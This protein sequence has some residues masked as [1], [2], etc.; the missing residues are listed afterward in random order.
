MPRDEQLN[1]LRVTNQQRDN[2]VATLREAVADGR[3]G[4]DEF[5]ERVNTAM[6]ARTRGDIVDV[7]E[8]LVEPDRLDAVITDETV[9]G[10]GPGFSWDNPLVLGEEKQTRT[11]LGQWRVPPFL[12]VHASAMATVRLDFTR[13][14]TVSPVIDLVVV[15]GSNVA[16]VLIVVPEG[17]GVSTQDLRVSGQSYSTSKVRTRPT[18]GHPRILVSGTTSGTVTVRHPSWWDEYKQR[19][20][21]EQNPPSS[22][23]VTAG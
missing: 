7:L 12:E 8:D 13:A 9:L 2:A 16:T 5:D 22:P 20:H 6:G 14:I 11:Q 3:L 4:F 23:A 15:G 19:K 1:R 10:E 21:L 17:W 18:G